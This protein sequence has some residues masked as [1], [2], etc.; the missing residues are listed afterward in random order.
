MPQ[1]LYAEN[2]IMLMKN[3]EED[4]NKWRIMLC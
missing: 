4:L 3:I 1:D 2:Y